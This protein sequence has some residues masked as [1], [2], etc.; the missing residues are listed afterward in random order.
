MSHLREETK[1]S[2]PTI[3]TSNES[4]YSPVPEGES[5]LPKWGI[6]WRTPTL[7]IG[8]FLLAIALAIVHDF[9]YRILVGQDAIYQRWTILAGTGL[10]FLSKTLFAACIGISHRQRRWISVLP[11][12]F[13][14]HPELRFRHLAHTPRQTNLNRRY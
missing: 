10:A 1:S 3:Q 4:Q 13:I 6:H 5:H 2:L 14:T 7:M 9:F 12:H 8:A 11:A